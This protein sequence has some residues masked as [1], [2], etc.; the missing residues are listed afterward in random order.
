MILFN[1]RLIVDIIY[2]CRY[3]TSLYDVNNK[4]CYLIKDKL[5]LFEKLEFLTTL[6]C[7]RCSFNVTVHS[8]MID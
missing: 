8:Y 5:R 2:Y 7:K 6:F 4:G 1:K 3:V